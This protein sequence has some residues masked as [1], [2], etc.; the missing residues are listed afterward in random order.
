M[1]ASFIFSPLSDRS[2]ALRTFSILSSGNSFFRMLLILTLFVF[3]VG[4]VPAVGSLLI[5]FLPSLTFFYGAVAGKAKTTAAYLIPV[6]FIFLISYSLHLKTP[7]VVILVMGVV[8]LTIAAA[9]TLKNSSIEKILVYPALIIIGAICAF[10]IYSGYQLSVNP[11]KIVQKFV[12]S[13]VSQNVNFYTQLPLNKEEIN[14]I[15][16]NK[17]LLVGIFTNIFPALAIIASFFVVWINVLLGRNSLRKAEL[18]LPQLN[19]L[20]RWKVPELIIW[21]F[22]STGG[23]LLFS[24]AEIRLFSMNV[25]ILTCF[26]YL[27][28]GLAI[29]SFLF[30]NKNVPLFFRYLFYFF[31]AVQQF[32]MI[33][34]FF[35]GLF[36]TWVDFRKYI[37]NNQIVI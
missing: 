7:Y 26:L 3:T 2:L 35:V 6:L 30:Q 27:L 31:I 4:F 21:I 32:L 17:E 34:I 8:G 10:F 1:P 23:L 16:N 37:H 5:I 15:K 24:A 19:E 12:E 18:F 28:Q 13:I 11:W 22:I 33:P 29:V 36:D 14:L 9:V 20:S 25:F